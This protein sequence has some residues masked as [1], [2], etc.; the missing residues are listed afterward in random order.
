MTAQIVTKYK[1]RFM[2]DDVLLRY[3]QGVITVYGT[4]D[5]EAL[6]LEKE[7]QRRN[8]EDLAKGYTPRFIKNPVDS[9]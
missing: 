9:K 7:I 4:Q 5:S 2:G 3:Y 6:E 1:Y 8:N